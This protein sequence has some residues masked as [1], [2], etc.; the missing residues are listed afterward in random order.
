MQAQ[1][2]RWKQLCERIA[3]EQDSMRF[4]T[5]VD[6]LNKLLEEK[7]RR[8]DEQRE[9]ARALGAKTRTVSN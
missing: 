5:L 2:E 1:I 8:L 6:E 3:V 7:E 4:M 9:Q